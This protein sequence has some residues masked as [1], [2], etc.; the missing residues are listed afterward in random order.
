MSRPQVE[1]N[2]MNLLTGL[3]GDLLEA[4]SPS[5]DTSYQSLETKMLIQKFQG[6]LGQL[7]SLQHDALDGK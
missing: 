4:S 6:F 1:I 2:F 3:F 7:C 5:S